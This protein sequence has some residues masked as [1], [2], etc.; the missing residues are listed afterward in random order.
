MSHTVLSQTKNEQE[1]RIDFSELPET[2][3]VIINE[4]PTSIKRLRFYKETDQ[5]K[6]SFEAKFKHKKR[7][8]SVEFSTNGILEDVELITKFKN[9]NPEV[10]KTI[11]TYF[12][13][14]FDKHKL[15]K[16]QKQ[17]VYSN[18]VKSSNFVNNILS[19]TSQTSSNFEIIAEV[20]SKKERTIREFT[21]NS[22][23][24]FLSE[25]ILKPTS[26]EHVLY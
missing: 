2:V 12:E 5:E 6:K 16:L 24:T 3:Q 7:I 26:Y 18:N 10:Q 13:N 11:T 21:F 4:L 19:N 17:Y 9:I 25:R 1:E 20:K 15:I 22:E 23:G 14:N 8:Y